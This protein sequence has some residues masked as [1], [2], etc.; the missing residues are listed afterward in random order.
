MLLSFLQF[1]VFETQA[2]NTFLTHEWIFMFW[3]YNVNQHYLFLDEWHGSVAS[4]C[5][6]YSVCGSKTFVSRLSPHLFFRFFLS[7]EDSS[8]L[9]CQLHFAK[10][11]SAL[12]CKKLTKLVKDSEA[13]KEELAKYRSLYGD[14]NAS[15]T[16]EEVRDPMTLLL[17]AR[18]SYAENSKNLTFE[19]MSRT[20]DHGRKPSNHFYDTLALLLQH[21]SLDYLHKSAI[22]WLKTAPRWSAN[23][24][25]NT[26]EV[27]SIQPLLL[28]NTCRLLTPPTPVRLRSDCIWSWWR[29][30]LTS[31]VAALWSWRWRTEASE[32]RWRTWRGH[33]VTLIR[34]SLWDRR[35]D[36]KVKSIF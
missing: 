20:E 2:A 30:R 16:V 36:F 21:L 7:Q 29:K 1:Q 5:V 18:Q 23:S 24:A 8:D 32:L 28:L 12:M 3:R 13:M 17:T 25:L 27:K 33:K 11:E 6:L 26:V 10:E 35:W 22:Y 4:L 9:K 31:W 15:L 14:I 19:G 34:P